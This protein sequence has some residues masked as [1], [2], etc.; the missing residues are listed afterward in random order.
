MTNNKITTKES[1]ISQIKSSDVIM[2]GGFGLIG[3]P[4]TMIDELI[5]HQVND[6]TVISNNVGEQGKGLGILLQQ[7]KI[8]RAIGSY[9]TSNRDVAKLYNAGKLEVELLPQGTLA[10]AIRA[11]GAGI[12]G[13]YTKTGV[14]TKLAE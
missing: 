5:H 2:V 1:A 3:S 12:L 6:L 7:G 11:G 14:G 9:F 10:E 8:K 13:F 4:L